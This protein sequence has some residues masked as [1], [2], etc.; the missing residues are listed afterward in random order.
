MY[1]NE[2]FYSLDERNAAILVKLKE[3][4]N[5]K[6]QERDCT[7]RDLFE[8]LDN[9]ALR[10]LPTTRYELKDYKQSTVQKNLHIFISKN[11]NYYSVPH[12]YVGK[13]VSVIISVKTDEFFIQTGMKVRLYDHSVGQDVID[14]KSYM[15][16]VKR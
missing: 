15:F 16:F 6:F 11:K 7:R 12:T 13:K 10:V 5:V 14:T 9:P 8:E 2:E 1:C 4:N 3:Y